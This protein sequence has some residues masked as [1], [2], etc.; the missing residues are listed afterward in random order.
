MPYG[1]FVAVCFLG[2]MEVGGLGKMRIGDEC[3]WRL[4]LFVSWMDGSWW[5]GQDEDRGVNED[6][7]NESNG[8]Q[9]CE[10]MTELQRNWIL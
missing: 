1:A 8:R 10:W 5:L 7:S 2:R 9:S 6:R 4:C 3:L